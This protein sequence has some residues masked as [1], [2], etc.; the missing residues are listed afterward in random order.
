[1]KEVTLIPLDLTKV[2]VHANV[3]IIQ[4]YLFIKL[5]IEGWLIF[6][7]GIHEEAQEDDINEAFSSYGTIKNLHLN[8]D[9]RTGYVKGYALVEYG[10]Y[11]EAK[12]AVEGI[13]KL[14]FFVCNR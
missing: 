11:D 9:R 1:M 2:L 6:V 3:I 14:Y 5:A 7:T 12:A 13:A 10:K 4:H 8:L